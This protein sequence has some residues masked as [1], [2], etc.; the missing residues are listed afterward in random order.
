MRDSRRFVFVV[1]IL[2]VIVQSTWGIRHDTFW[3]EK[4]PPGCEPCPKNNEGL[5][6]TPICGM[7]GIAYKNFCYLT[8]RNC[9]AKILKKKPVF[10]S[11]DPKTC[12]LQMKMYNTFSDKPFKRRRRAIKLLEKTVTENGGY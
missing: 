7:N 9:I 1:T 10:P 3:G 11:K 6:D 2:F 12:G 5:F 8:L 4:A